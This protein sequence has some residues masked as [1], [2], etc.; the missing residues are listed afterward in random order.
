MNGFFPLFLFLRSNRTFCVNSLPFKRFTLKE[1][2][3]H[4]WAIKRKNSDLKVGK[5]KSVQ[6]SSFE[7][8]ESRK[9]IIARLASWNWSKVEQQ[10]HQHKCVETCSRIHTHNIILSFSRPIKSINYLYVM[11]FNVCMLFIEKTQSAKR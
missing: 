8:I 1:K 9:C 3:K 6:I 11:L 10:K 7:T 5:K 4:N 2:T